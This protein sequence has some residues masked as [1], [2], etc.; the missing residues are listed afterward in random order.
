MQIALSMVLASPEEPG[1]PERWGTGLQAK[2]EGPTHLRWPARPH[3]GSPSPRLSHS[4]WPRGV[5]GARGTAGYSGTRRPWGAE[6]SHGRQGLHGSGSTRDSTLVTTQH[7][8]AEQ[9]GRNRAA[10]VGGWGEG[11]GPLGHRDRRRRRHREGRR[12]A[13]SKGHRPVMPSTAAEQRAA[14]GFQPASRIRT[15]LDGPKPL[16][17]PYDAHLPSSTKQLHLQSPDLRATPRPV[18]LPTCSTQHPG[19]QEPLGLQ[20]VQSWSGQGPCTQDGCCTSQVPNMGCH[21]DRE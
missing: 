5:P 12:G 3:A 16:P 21:M 7:N 18:T 6:V 14:E 2:P 19:H 4:R 9:S 13:R 11:P 8:A 1:R 15:Q 17:L 10:R 20:L